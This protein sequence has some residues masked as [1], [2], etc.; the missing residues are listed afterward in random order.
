MKNNSG[1]SIL[2]VLVGMSISLITSLVV[3]AM[4]ENSLKSQRS[5]ATKADISDTASLAKQALMNSTNCVSLFGA[6]LPFIRTQGTPSSPRFLAN[7]AASTGAIEMDAQSL[8][9]PANGATE[10]ALILGVGGNISSGAQVTSMKI[11]DLRKLSDLRYAANLRFEV[12][13]SNVLGAPTLVQ[14]I[15]LYINTEATAHASVEAVS[16]CS[17]GASDSSASGTEANS[18]RTTLLVVHLLAA[19]VPDCPSGWEK[20]WDGYSHMMSAGGIGTGQSSDLSSTGSCLEEF[21]STSFIECAANNNCDFHT[22]GDYDY[23]LTSSQSTEGSSQYSISYNRTNAATFSASIELV[24]GMISRCTVCKKSVSGILVRH[25]QKT[26]V[27]PACPSGMTSLW[28]GYSF[29]FANGGD[30]SAASADLGRTGSCLPYLQ[31]FPFVECTI[32]GCT[33][34][35]GADYAYWLSA[36]ETPTDEGPSQGNTNNEQKI[37]RCRVC[38]Y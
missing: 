1:F 24:K 37:S 23:W 12:A 38:E 8:R 11:G 34:G 29:S 26:T 10:G 6:Q 25:S 18:G 28:T 4:N 13:R 21:R 36:K 17:S 30:Y 22:G 9:F 15:P 14:K 35:T 7:L 32:N 2:E 16:S 3:L 5:I 20:L 19:I 31:T 33:Y 27:I